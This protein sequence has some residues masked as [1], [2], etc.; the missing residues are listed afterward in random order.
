MSFIKVNHSE[1]SEGGKK[2]EPGTYQATITKTECKTSSTGNP[3]V[4]LDYTIRK[5]IEQPNGGAVVRYD[6]LP[7]TE[8]TMWRVQTYLKAAGVPDGMEC[9]T[10]EEFASA[11]K[12]RNVEIDVVDRESNNG[13]VYANVDRVRP[14]IDAVEADADVDPFATGDGKIDLKDDDLPF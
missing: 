13:K 6:N 7:V 8:K 10:I 5:D 2:I 4:V 11:L 3:M 12:D 1:A 14:A 9:D